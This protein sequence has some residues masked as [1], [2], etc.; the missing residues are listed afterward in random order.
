MSQLMLHR[1]ARL[2]DRAGLDLVEAPPPTDTWFPLRHSQVLT[3]VVETLP[4]NWQG[5]FS[6]GTRESR[7][8]ATQEVAQTFKLPQCVSWLL[9][10]EAIA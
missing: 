4:A 6:D 2:V 10:R 9:Q 5:F 1:G 8:S 7:C 3:T